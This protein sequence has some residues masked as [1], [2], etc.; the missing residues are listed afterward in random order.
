MDKPLNSLMFPGLPDRYVIPEAKDGASAYE[1]AVQQG[2]V[3]SLDDWLASLKGAPG[4]DFT[5]KA[6]YES[7]SA[8]ES[9]VPAPADGD[10]YGVGTSAPYDI[11]VWDAVHSEWV[12]NGQIQGP[13]GAAGPYFTPAVSE[14]GDLSWT[15]NGGLPNPSV[16][17]LKGPKGDKGDKGDPGKY[18]EPFYVNCTVS[19]PNIY[20]EEVTHDKTFDEILAAYQAGRPCYA[21][22]NLTNDEK[23][24]LPLTNILAAEE[25]KATFSMTQM[26]MGDTPEE[27]DVY[28]VTIAPS[29]AE[30]FW[31]CRYT[32]GPRDQSL[33]RVTVSDNGKF[34]RVVNGAWA[35]ASISNANGGSF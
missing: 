27:L 11:Y 12:N 3:G 35:A 18:P 28:Y 30:G 2:F 15:N 34:L 4:T 9:A 24:L 7:L 13:T 16:V 25:A 23:Y 32:S 26:M 33:P 6:Y 29:W 14:N 31:G 17:N 21:V 10:V 22:L 5:V 8:L 19:G 20:D 1:L